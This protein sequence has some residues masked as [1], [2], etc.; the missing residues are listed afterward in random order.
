MSGQGAELGVLKHI[1][2][3][4]YRELNWGTHKDCKGIGTTEPRGM[5]S[6]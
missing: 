3:C 2:I 4:K 5:G 6:T 1:K